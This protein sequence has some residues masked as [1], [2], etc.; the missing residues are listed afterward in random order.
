MGGARERSGSTKKTNG[1]AGKGSGA[2]AARRPD[3]KAGGRGGRPK[4]GGT[5]S[6]RPRRD[7]YDAA[8][9]QLISRTPVLAL[10]L[11]N[12][13]S[14]FA[15]AS[16]EEVARCIGEVRAG[17]VPVDER[18]ALPPSLPGA[19]NED[20]SVEDGPVFFDT[21]F[22]AR[23]PSGGSAAVTVNVEAQR[24]P[25]PGNPL[26]KRGTYYASRIL[27]SQRRTWPSGSDYGRLEK[28]YSIWVCINFPE[29]DAGTAASYDIRESHLLGRRDRPPEE[30]D[31]LSVVILC[32]PRER[33]APTTGRDAAEDAAWPGMEGFMKALAAIFSPETDAG[34]KMR[35]LESQLGPEE[36]DRLKGDVKRMGSLE[37]YAI[38]IGVERGLKQGV[39]KGRRQGIEQGRKEEHEKTKLDDIVGIMKNLSLTLDEAFRALEVP[40]SEQD[41]FRN[42]LA[43]R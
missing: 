14:E 6:G 3:K 28:A 4:S 34:T 19:R 39:E 25:D 12:A 26:T 41:T 2:A 21:L 42:M 17:E 33:D 32:L 23:L 31:M 30:Y 20:D 18:E 10:I 37:D 9:K 40:K 1:G 13:T 29:G 7:S 8:C 43:A 38:Q 36:A 27:S 22:R 35:A 15:G 5:R 11:R 16:L 24:A